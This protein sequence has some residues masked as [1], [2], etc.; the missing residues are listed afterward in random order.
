MIA[1]AVFAVL[2][3]SSRQGFSPMALQADVRIRDARGEVCL[4]VD[5][6]TS[7]LSCWRAE[8]QPLFMQRHYVLDD[9]DY[10]VT[11]TVDGHIRSHESVHVIC[12]ETGNSSS[13]SKCQ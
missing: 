4:S 9:G 7:F 6:P 5:G 8:E 13:R 10:E 3:L 1:D 2:T 12:S 11:L